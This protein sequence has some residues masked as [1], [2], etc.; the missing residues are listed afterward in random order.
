[1]PPG[2]DKQGVAPLASS[3]DI[4]ECVARARCHGRAKLWGN[5]RPRGDALGWCCLLSS[6][7]TVLMSYRARGG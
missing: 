2:A 6:A 3:V 4:G 7:E 1:M 5:A